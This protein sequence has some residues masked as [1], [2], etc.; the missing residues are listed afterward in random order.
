MRRSRRTLGLVL[1]AVLLLTQGGCTG[2]NDIEPDASPETGYD[3][4]EEAGVE[5][6]VGSLPRTGPLNWRSFGTLY[7]KRHY[8]PPA[9]LWDEGLIALRSTE[10][11]VIE[12]VQ[13]DDDPRT[14]PLVYAGAR[15]SPPSTHTSVPAGKW[16]VATEKAECYHLSPEMDPSRAPVLV[17]RLGS[18]RRADRARFARASNRGVV[19]RYRTED[20][21]AYEAPYS[22]QIRYP[23]TRS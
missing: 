13:V 6:E 1:I 23:N 2:G 9:E 19:V 20:G 12:G 8:T 18:A 11:I 3:S 14:A 7:F 16:A 10:P 17:V 15:V 5:W 21:K 4:C 22:L